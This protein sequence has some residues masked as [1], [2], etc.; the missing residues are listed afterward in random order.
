VGAL[1]AAEPVAIP[2]LQRFNGVHIQ[3]SSVITLPDELAGT[4]QGCGGSAPKN[5]SASVKIQV[6]LNMN[7]GQL[8]GPYLQPGKQHDR[9]SCLQEKQLPQGALH[10]ADLGYF[11]LKRLKSMK[12]HGVFW[13][14]R[15]RPQCGLY[16]QDNVKWELVEFLTTYCH[17]ENPR[18][19]IPIFLGIK[20]R[21]PCRLLATRVPEKVVSERRGK[22][23][24][25]AR[26]RCVKPS[27]RQLALAQWTVLVTC[28]PPELLSLDEAFVLMRIRWQIELLFKLWKS[29]GHIDD[30]R[31]KKP[32][33]ILCELYAKL[34]VMVIQHWILLSGC[35]QHPNRSLHK[36]AQTIR[37]HAIHL[38]VALSSG[39]LR[40][41]R[42]ALEIIQRCLS[43]GCRLNKRKTNPNTYQLLLQL[44]ETGLN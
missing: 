28:V 42:E 38:A 16:D 30:W 37:K 40:R 33:R 44:S 26:R 15:I 9:S 10:I 29:S 1:I 24:V 3:D 27:K 34:L 41:L 20:E 36:A 5:T 22:I 14:S 12:E 8:S 6:R 31:S 4:W 43:A 17:D 19:D 35:W 7:T 21:I 11:S 18:L 2:I 25:D 13:L 39:R 32:L 23:K